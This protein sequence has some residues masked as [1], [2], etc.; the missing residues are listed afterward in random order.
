M[1]TT[2]S[3]E[4]LE[5]KCLELLDEVTE[6]GHTFVITKDGLPIANLMPIPLDVDPF[7]AMRGSVTILGDIIS[8]LEN[9][10]EALK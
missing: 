6:Q 5:S 3:A 8:P 9:E 10:W 4:E 7:G 2:I 1:Q